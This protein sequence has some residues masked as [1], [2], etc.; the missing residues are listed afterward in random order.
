MPAQ[1]SPP[2]AEPASRPKKA[3]P[4]FHWIAFPMGV[5]KR[6]MLLY[7]VCVHFF[8]LNKPIMEI[9]YETVIIYALC[10]FWR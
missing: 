2:E 6:G 10:R 1:P 3:L 4:R 5:E 9:G 8:T 7:N